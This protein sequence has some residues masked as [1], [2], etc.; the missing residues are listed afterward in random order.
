MAQ[1]SFIKGQGRGHMAFCLYWEVMALTKWLMQTPHTW[2]TVQRKQQTFEHKEQW[3]YFVS[4]LFTLPLPK[5]LLNFWSSLSQGPCWGLVTWNS[6]M[7]HSGI[8]VRGTEFLSSVLVSALAS[9]GHQAITVCSLPG[10]RTCHPGCI[11]FAVLKFKHGSSDF[12]AHTAPGTAG[13]GWIHAAWGFPG[14]VLVFFVSFL[15]SLERGC[16]RV[17]CAHMWIMALFTHMQSNLH[18]S[19]KI[20]LNTCL[21]IAISSLLCGPWAPGKKINLLLMMNNLHWAVQKWCWE[22]TSPSHAV[23]I[24]ESELEARIW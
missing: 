10:P 5:H 8:A 7:L 18:F 24:W 11:M 23:V 17:P 14:P 15:T 6:S 22:E 1:A 2:E 9:G 20:Y 16:I 12:L 13:A 19:F 21:H 3:R 4:V